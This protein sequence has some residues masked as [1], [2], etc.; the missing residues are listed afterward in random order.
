MEPV[1]DDPKTKEEL[2]KA[3]YVIANKLP[4]SAVEEHNLLKRASELLKPINPWVIQ[5]FISE[6]VENLVNSEG[7]DDWDKQYEILIEWDKILMLLL[8]KPLGNANSPSKNPEPT[9]RGNHEL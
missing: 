4:A 6:H 7:K 9:N 5:D 3:L 2:S 8:E 1:F